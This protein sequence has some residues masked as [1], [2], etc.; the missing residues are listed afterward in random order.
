MS[1][2][3]EHEALNV[4]EP[5]D[6]AAAAPAAEAGAPAELKVAAIDA[7][8]DEAV[9][10]TA[11]E[12]VAE[13]AAPAESM[14]ELMANAPAATA[15]EE[16]TA[17]GE[18]V[19]PD[20]ETAAE[21]ARKAAKRGRPRLKLEELPVGTEMRGKVVGLAD[22]G[23]FVDI[24]AVTD[25]LVHITEMGSRRAKKAEEVVKLGD[26]VDVWVKE[27][28]LEG[29]RV[30]LSMR[31]RSTRSIDTLTKGEQL[32]GEVTSVTKYG[33]FVDIGAETE[34]LIHISELS[35]KRVGKAEDVVKVGD[36]VTVWV[37]E[38][39]VAANRVS[40]SMR[41]RPDRPMADLKVGDV[42]QGTVTSVTKYGVFVNIGAETEGLVH[43][44]EMASG[45]IDD[46]NEVSKPGDTVEVRIKE[47]DRGRNR[48]SLSMAGLKNDSGGRQRE[49]PQREE[50][51]EPEYVPE[52]T[53][54]MPTVVELALRRAMGED[55][56]DDGAV[57]V[58]KAAADPKAKPNQ[59]QR[60]LSDVYSR[61]LDE[62]RTSKGQDSD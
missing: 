50:R 22:F 46:P 33:A 5:A 19:A 12:P 30:A 58:D 55:V 25:G 35:D 48:I 38:V 13:A 49:Q 14:A 27:V 61:M 53:E 59:K 43:I 36:T 9:T 41:T 26:T 51:M 3:T 39:D 16:A 37:K 4:D 62:Y 34:G 54:R 7:V 21:E 11:D 17:A 29:G 2:M 6:G 18:A 40:L 23:A 52:P 28:D 60:A 56:G 8:A 31:P 44:S 1:E 15:A 10:A 45:F 32:T 20:P 47:V 57:T 24:G 42:L